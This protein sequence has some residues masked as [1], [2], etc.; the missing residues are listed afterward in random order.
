MRALITGGAGFIGSHLA[1]ALIGRGWSVV[2]VDNFITGKRANVEHL[3]GDERFTLIECDLE[4]APRIA[5]DAVFHLA[6]PASPVGYGRHP[7]ET[8]RVNSQGTWAA[9]E[10]ARE[11]QA[12]FLLASTSEVYGDPLQHPQDESYFGNVDP[13]GPRA[14]YDEGK[15]F[16]EALTMSYVTTHG[17]DARIVRI[18]N[19]YGPRNDLDDGRM[20]PTFAGQALR[21]EPITVHG[22]GSQTRSLCYIDD[23]VEGLLAAM[24][25]EGTSARVYNLGQP[26]EH[27]VLEF[28]QMIVRLAGSSSQTVHLAPRPADIER[29]KPDARRAEAELGWR[30][31]RTLEY[32]LERTIAWYREQLAATPEQ[33]RVGHP[34]GAGEAFARLS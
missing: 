13:V 17:V 27:S 20:V 33:L 28:A 23:L 30:A 25:S 2:A 3:A 14:C 31:Q 6:S 15:R 24:F 18:F 22:D 26:R 32:G 21:G 11:N 34:A 1:D 16:A 12:P 7:L 19:C 9:L 4:S 10:I 5:C 8:L 29:R